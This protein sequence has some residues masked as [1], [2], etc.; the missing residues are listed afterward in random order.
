MF[1]S[2]AAAVTAFQPHSRGPGARWDFGYLAQA[3]TSSTA[4]DT[5]EAGYRMFSLPDFAAVC[6]EARAT[7]VMRLRGVSA[8]I[9]AKADRPFDPSVLKI[10]ALD[11]SGTILPG[12]PVAIETELWSPVLETP[13]ARVADGTVTP[14]RPGTFKLRIRTICDAPGAE[15]FIVVQAIQ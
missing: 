14:Q 2:L 6:A 11:R 12:V 8:Q 9:R 1:V 13:M 15:T 7:D 4:N 10:V 5:I 3:R